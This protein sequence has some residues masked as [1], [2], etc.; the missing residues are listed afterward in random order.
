MNDASFDA[1][2]IPFSDGDDP[3]EINPEFIEKIEQ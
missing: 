2:D 3:L 1:Y